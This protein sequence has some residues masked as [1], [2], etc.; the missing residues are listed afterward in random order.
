[1]NFLKLDSGDWVSSRAEI[2]GYFIAHFTNIFTSLNPPIEVEMLDLFSPIIS[3]EENVILC[4]IP[5]EK[6][7]L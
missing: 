6:E 1:V 7:V 2:G 5:I 4:S 3:N